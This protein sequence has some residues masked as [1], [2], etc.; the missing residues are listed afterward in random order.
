VDAGADP[1]VDVDPPETTITKQPKR[2]T[3][4]RKAK[5]AFA[6]DEPRSAFECRLDAGT[7]AACPAN[8]SKRV[9]PGKHKLE[10][11]A[12]DAAGNADPTPATARWKVKRRA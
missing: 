5:F 3:T 10:V 12:V 9:K 7:F 11:R 8:F 2:K 4:K 6:A 1:P